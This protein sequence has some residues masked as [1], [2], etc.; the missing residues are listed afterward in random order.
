[1]WPSLML[2]CKLAGFARLDNLLNVSYCHWS[3]ETLLKAFLA[4]ALTAM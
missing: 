2:Y 3:I 1:M 4:K